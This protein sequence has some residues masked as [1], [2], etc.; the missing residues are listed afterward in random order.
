MRKIAIALSLFVSLNCYGQSIDEFKTYIETHRSIAEAGEINWS[1]YFRGL[2]SRMVNL[3]AP[4]DMLERTSR[5]IRDAELYE[6]GSIDRSEFEYR[7]RSMNVQQANAD[8]ARENAAR[9]DAIIA[10]QQV[11]ARDQQRSSA[12]LAVAA[13]LLQAGAPRALAPVPM[14]A[15]PA[16][17]MGFLQ[18]QSINGTLRYCKY[19]NGIVNTISVMQICPLN[20]Q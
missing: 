20:S 7:Q 13:Q 9:A 10:Q 14:A 1:A 11:D 3:N 16:G 19:S 4:G 12:V 18:D 8:R 15:A 5:M 2:Y 17:L 6:A